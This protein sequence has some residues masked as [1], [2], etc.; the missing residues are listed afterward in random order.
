MDIFF[1]IL[2]REDG[3]MKD[4]EILYSHT[5]ES[6]NQRFNTQPKTFFCKNDTIHSDYTGKD[7]GAKDQNLENRKKRVEL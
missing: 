4:L 6:Y 1:Q 7:W 2:P 5:F 3:L